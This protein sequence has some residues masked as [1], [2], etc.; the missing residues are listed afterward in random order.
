[1]IKK[2]I[3]LKQRSRSLVC[4]RYI[5]VCEVQ[6]KENVEKLYQMMDDKSGKDQTSE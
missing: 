1:M 2:T 6:K 3:T 5:Y 4:L